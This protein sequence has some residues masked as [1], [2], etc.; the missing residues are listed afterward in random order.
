MKRKF[1]IGILAIVLPLVVSGCNFNFGPVRRPTSRNKEDS[2]LS[3]DKESS[4]SYISTNHNH[5]YGALETIQEPTC[6]ESGVKARRCTICGETSQTQIIPATGHSFG[7]EK[8]IINGKVYQECRNCHEML[9]VTDKYASVTYYDVDNRVTLSELVK[10]GRALQT[11]PD[12]SYVPYGYEFIGWANVNN[13]GQMWDFNNERLNYVAEDI[14]LKPVLVK[15]MYALN[16]F[17]AELDPTITESNGGRGMQGSTYSGGAYGAQLI[18]SD[19]KTS[20]NSIN[21]SGEYVLNNGYARKATSSDPDSNIFGAVVHFFYNRGNKITWQINSS[22][23][24]TDATIILRFSAEYGS[25]QTITDESTDCCYSIDDYGCPIRVNGERLEY[26]K[27]TFHNI[28]N[29]NL[30]PCQD[31]LISQTVSLNEGLNTIELEVDNDT[32]FF[33]TIQSVAPC[34]DCLK[35]YTDSTLS[36]PYETVANLNRN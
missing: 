29:K 26:G 16:T 33:G 7:G 30:L 3:T 35:I 6:T 1:T 13:G 32:N 28:D 4:Y 19:Y 5:R 21:A 31:Y 36:W 2:S 22:A 15:S 9:E 8:Q 17:E 10:K 34:I 20:D 11:I 18:Y 12:N 24:V 23:A 25:E 27:I 14:V